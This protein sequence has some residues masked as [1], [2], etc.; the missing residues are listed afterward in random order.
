VPEGFS[1][2]AGR[3][4]LGKTRLA[5]DWAVAVAADGAAMGSIMVE[6]GDVLY[7][8]VSFQQVVHSVLGEEAEVAKLQ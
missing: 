2:L 4:K 3:Q 8:D 5:F 1:V 7:L 6:Q